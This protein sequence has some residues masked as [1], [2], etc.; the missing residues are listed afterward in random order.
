MGPP[1][2]GSLHARL[3]QPEGEDKSLTNRRSQRSALGP[4]MI[5]G[6]LASSATDA[7]AA[8]ETRE[9]NAGDEGE[10]GVGGPFGDATSPFGDETSP[11]P[12]EI[13]AKKSPLVHLVRLPGVPM[14]PG[15]AQRCAPVR[16][17]FDERGGSRVVGRLCGVFRHFCAFAYAASPYGVIHLG[18]PPRQRSLLGGQRRVRREVAPHRELPSVRNPVNKTRRH[19]NCQYEK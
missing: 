18:S 3:A 8:A 16:I 10:L 13:R 12:P 7:A 19:S 15:G 6:V 17:S 2:V 9:A 1:G 14:D 5:V 4:T 11:P